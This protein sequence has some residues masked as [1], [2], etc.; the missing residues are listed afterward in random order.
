MQGAGSSKLQF[1]ATGAASAGPQLAQQFKTEST[2]I[3]VKHGPLTNA[4]VNRTVQSSPPRIGL[5]ADRRISAR[6]LI[7]T[8]VI[9]ASALGFW[10]LS[11]NPLATRLSGRLSPPDRAAITTADKTAGS[12][13]ASSSEMAQPDKPPGANPSATA[14]SRARSS[15]TEDQGSSSAEVSRPG[16]AALM[17]PPGKPPKILTGSSSAPEPS[18]PPVAPAIPKTASLGVSS[19]PLSTPSRNARTVPPPSVPVQT[20]FIPARAVSTQQPIYP[21]VAKT[22]RLQ[23]DVVLGVT[24]SAKGTVEHVTQI[25]GNPLLAQAAT[26]AVR[27]WKYEPATLNGRPT[28]STLQVLMKF[29]LQ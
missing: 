17:V 29:H 10:A 9:A 19:L 2:D 8:A 26:A 11:S 25:D 28:R 13:P 16:E 27:K 14:R 3:K 23:G 5:I 6:H 7:P 12:A 15:L 18:E 20:T 22:M 21:A 4:A 24:L 1:Q